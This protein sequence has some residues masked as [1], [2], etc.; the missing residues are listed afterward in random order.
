MHK[1]TN[2]IAELP[3]GWLNRHTGRYYASAAQAHAAV[4]RAD[5]KVKV[6]AITVINW[7]PLTTTGTA[8]IRAIGGR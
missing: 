2:T 5:R 6:G 7:L 3:A 8:A 4:L 1:T